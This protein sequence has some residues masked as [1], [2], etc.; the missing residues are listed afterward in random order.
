MEAEDTTALQVRC[1]Q[2]VVVCGGEGGAGGNQQGLRWRNLRSMC[3]V[4]KQLYRFQLM[5][6]DVRDAGPASE[7][8]LT[9]SHCVSS[10]AQHA[11]P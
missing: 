3:L 7:T 6:P 9:N 8:G 1:M 11:Q 4:S 5:P 10:S 2:T